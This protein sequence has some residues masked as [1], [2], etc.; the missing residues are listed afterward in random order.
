MTAYNECGDSSY[1]QTITVQP[2]TINAFFST[3][4]TRGCDPLTVTFTDHS[5]GSIYSSWCFNYFRSSDSC[6]PGSTLVVPP[7][8]SVTRTFTA[9]HYLVELYATDGCSADTFFQNITVDT[10]PIAAFTYIDR[11]CPSSP[12]VFTNTSTS[13]PG[14]V[15][16]GYH[17]TLGNGDSSLLRSP[18]YVYRTGGNYHVCMSLLVAS[19]CTDTICHD[20]NVLNATHATITT[21]NTCINTQPVSFGEVLSPR[22]S[23]GTATFH[24]DFGDGNTSVSA[25]PIHNYADTG[26]YRVQ[27]VATRAS[28]KDSIPC[29]MSEIPF[30]CWMILSFL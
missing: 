28:Q 6:A 21:A 24:W 27:Y 16:T 1:T 29:A 25:T 8:S 2:R 9:G 17:W 23:L 4:V 15:I 30:Y 19:G 13:V 14:S 12:V 22:D 18:S 20:V 11:V 3:S 5:A 10:S 7:G 26:T